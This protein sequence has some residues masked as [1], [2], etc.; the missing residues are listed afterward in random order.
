MI[1][2]KRKSCGKRVR[3]RMK[4]VMSKLI[5]FLRG[6]KLQWDGCLES[7][8]YIVVILATFAFSKAI[9]LS[10]GFPGQFWSIVATLGT[11][12]TAVAAYR[13][14]LATQGTLNHQINS[15]R[16]QKSPNLI[17]SLKNFEINES[18]FSNFRGLSAEPY[19][20]LAFKASNLSQ[21]SINI[22]QVIFDFPNYKV[23]IQTDTS[24]SIAP[25]RTESFE[26]KKKDAFDPGDSG[27]V[28][29]FFFY[30]ATGQQPH[31]LIWEYEEKNFIEDTPVHSLTL[32]TRQTY[33]DP[34]SA[35]NIR[36]SFNT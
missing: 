3:T 16:E 32:G 1:N 36:E 18:S 20:R 33:I 15:E 2:D 30:G 31:G 11:L 7:T 13:T 22:Y 8:R 28:L 9:T 24:F 19:V 25:N 12:L 29:L 5:K 10:S 34:E 14:A 26:V 17:L 23:K 4:F 6:T 35:A 21:F 27:R